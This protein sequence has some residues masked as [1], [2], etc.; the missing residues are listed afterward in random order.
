M[1]PADR[2]KVRLECNQF[3]PERCINMMA[4]QLGKGEG[5]TIVPKPSE[6]SA[7]GHDGAMWPGGGGSGSLPRGGVAAA[8]AG[9]RRLH[10]HYFQTQTFHGSQLPSHPRVQILTL[11]NCVTLGNSPDLPASVPSPVKQD[12]LH[13]LTPCLWHKNLKKGTAES[14]LLGAGNRRAHVNLLQH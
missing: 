7:E 8:G 6:L 1:G 14:V 2:E 4:R 3:F 9:K 10:G 13:F 12:D 5:P 11:I